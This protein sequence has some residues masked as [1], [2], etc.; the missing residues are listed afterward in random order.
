[1]SRVGAGLYRNWLIRT[2]GKKDEEKL[3]NLL[4]YISILGVIRQVDP[5]VGEKIEKRGW[6]VHIILTFETGKEEGGRG[7]EL[8]V[9]E[10]K[11]KKNSKAMGK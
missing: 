11:H 2:K 6:R 8:A 9:P 7:L 10:K 1:V 4:R 5:F 3:V